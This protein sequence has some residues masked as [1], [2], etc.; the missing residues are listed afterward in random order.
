MTDRRQ[1]KK[2]IPQDLHI[3]SVLSERDESIAAEQTVELI[4][5]FRYA[6]T[7][8][9]S[10]HFEQISDPDEYIKCVKTYGFHAGTEVC[11]GEHA[12]DAAEM[13]FEYFICH[14]SDR[15]ADYRGIETLLATGRPVIVAHPMAHGTEPEKASGQHL[16]GNQQSLCME[17][18]LAPILYAPY[19]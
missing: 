11:R 7:M 16:P 6:E 19:T 10:D 15:T 4:K 8:G 3:H 1:N 18:Q 2:L 9:I 17:K 14:C 13:D 5:E 12:H